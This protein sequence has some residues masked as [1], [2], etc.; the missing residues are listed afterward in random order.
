VTNATD[1]LEQAKNL[2][3]WQLA[4]A[5]M[6]A[7]AAYS[8]L[9]GVNDFKFDVG[10]HVSALQL[11]CSPSASLPFKLV[12]YCCNDVA[13]NCT[14]MDSGCNDPYGAYEQWC[15]PLLCYDIK[16]K[17]TYVRVIQVAS[18]AGGLYGLFMLVLVS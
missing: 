14:D 15:D 13:A 7:A 9:L 5:E 12:E 2:S 17:E 1:A 8:Y 3:S 4:V 6:G 10:T 18:A 11:T 16:R